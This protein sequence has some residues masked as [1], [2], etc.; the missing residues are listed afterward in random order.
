MADTNQNNQ[1]QNPDGANT[2]DNNRAISR[3]RAGSR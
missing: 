2:G 1:Q 3:I